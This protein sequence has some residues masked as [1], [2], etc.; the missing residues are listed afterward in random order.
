MPEHEDYMRALDLKNEE[1]KILKEKIEI[2]ERFLENLPC[3][4]KKVD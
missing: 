3:L 2:Y 4:K 1:I